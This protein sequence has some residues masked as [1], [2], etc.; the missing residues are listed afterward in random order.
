[1]RRL[2]PVGFVEHEAARILRV[3]ADVE[4]KAVVFQRAR[5]VGVPVDQLGERLD[6]VR[7]G[8]EL[9]DDHIGHG[10]VSFS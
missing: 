5:V 10:K 1:V 2:V 3:L 7:L 8:A 6:L 4:R 9:D